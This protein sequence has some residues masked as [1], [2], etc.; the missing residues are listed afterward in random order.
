MHLQNK[1][2][3]NTGGIAECLGLKHNRTNTTELLILVLTLW[4]RSKT[5]TS[6]MKRETIQVC[7]QAEPIHHLQMKVK[8]Q[9]T[10][11]CVLCLFCSKL[12]LHG[13]V[14]KCYQVTFCQLEG[15][16]I[17]TVKNIKKKSMPMPVTIIVHTQ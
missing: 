3:L 5:K 16:S 14:M 12:K 10:I 11:V 15:K 1:A 2:K 7:L 13:Q 4:F 6:G 8:I 17:K 9:R